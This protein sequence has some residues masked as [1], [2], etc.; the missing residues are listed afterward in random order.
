MDLNDLSQLIKSI[1]T[2]YVPC[3]EGLQMNDHQIYCT[4]ETDL[5]FYSLINFSKMESIKVP[6]LDRI[7]AENETT[8]FIKYKK[9]KILLYDKELK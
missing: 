9:N 8:L 2:D 5:Q 6:K 1:K 3:W 4:T 7:L